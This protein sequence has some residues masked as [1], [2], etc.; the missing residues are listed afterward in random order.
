M[1]GKAMQDEQTSRRDLLRAGLGVAMVGPVAEA[2]GATSGQSAGRTLVLVRL[3]GGNDGLNTIIPYR[4]PFYR[5]LRPNLSRAADGA[6]PLDGRLALH[7]SLRPLLPLYEQ[8]RMTIVPAV[9]AAEAD[10]SH[11]GACRL[12]ANGGRAHPADD[13][14][15]SWWRRAFAERAGR[16]PRSM[17]IGW[18]GRRADGTDSPGVTTLP[19]HRVLHP[20]NAGSLSYR[21]GM[22]R[23]TLRVATQIV[24]SP[25]PPDLMFATMGGFDT[26]ADQLPSH[27]RIL[28]ELADG[29]AAMHACLAERGA[30]D[31]PLVVV[32]SEFGRRPAENACGGTD[33]G[34]AGPVLLIGGGLPGGLCGSLPSLQDVDPFGTLR[35]TTSMTSLCAA[36]ADV[37]VSQDGS[38]HAMRAV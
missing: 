1:A 2:L 34:S 16:T 36:L 27:A 15:P 14:T 31:R 35:P 28:S 29:L 17:W 3:A 12:W 30:A 6:I 10:Y 8:G 13:T 33:H 21:P 7:A 5:E 23:Q 22:A 20:M 38:S 37:W 9:G 19:E 4:D 11:R 32:W 24:L 25:Q 18:P 26:H